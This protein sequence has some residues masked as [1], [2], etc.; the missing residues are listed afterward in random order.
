MTGGVVYQCLYPEFG[1]TRAA[2]TRR[3][4]SGADVTVEPIGVTGLADVRELLAGYVAELRASFQDDEAAAVESLMAE[5]KHRF[6]RIV[7]G[8]KRPPKA[9]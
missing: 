4:A 7:P 3:L 8:H 1:F 6:V 5:A 2:L 9:E